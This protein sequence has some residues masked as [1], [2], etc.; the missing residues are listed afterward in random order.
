M[1]STLV[2]CAADVAVDDEPRERFLTASHGRDL[3]LRDAVKV[4]T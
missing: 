3:A 1:K 4:A 2:S